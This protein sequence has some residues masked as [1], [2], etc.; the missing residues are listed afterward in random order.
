MRHVLIRRFWSPPLF[1]DQPH[2]AQVV[3]AVALPVL[4]GLLCGL[5][6]GVDA[7][8]YAVLVALSVFGA[9]GAGRQHA[10]AGAGALRGLAAGLIFSACVL[11]GHA[12][13]GLATDVLPHPA[14]LQ[15]A[16]AAMIA[17]TLGGTG[18][19]SRRMYGRAAHVGR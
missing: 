17:T 18:G 4:W 9:F 2:A 8:A 15:L 13:S 16:F 1:R 5:V 10:G 7:V 14:V 11:V 19:F 3:N 12:I 6:A